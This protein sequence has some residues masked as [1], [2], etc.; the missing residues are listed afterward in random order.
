MN[1]DNILAL[2]SIPNAITM[3]KRYIGQFIEKQTIKKCFYVI[4]ISKNGKVHAHGTIYAGRKLNYTSINESVRGHQIWIK[5]AE[6]TA[7]TDD[8]TGRKKRLYLDY[9]YGYMTKMFKVPSV[10]IERGTNYYK[11]IHEDF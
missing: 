1:K 7:N 9:W 6:T 4:E 5:P 2:T 3:L 11:I 8:S 10:Y